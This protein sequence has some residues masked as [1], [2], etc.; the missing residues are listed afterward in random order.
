MAPT[1][2]AKHVW[3]FLLLNPITRYYF[4]YWFT[5]FAKIDPHKKILPK[6]PNS[7]NAKNI[8]FQSYSV[9]YS[10]GTKSSKW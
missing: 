5:N 3:S 6:F 1:I 4:K 10:A 9:G 8:R 2:K 7:D